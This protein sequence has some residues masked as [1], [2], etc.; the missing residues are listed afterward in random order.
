ML[1][2][3]YIDEFRHAIPTWCHDVWI[4]YKPQD[5]A[6][7]TCVR[8]EYR[9]ANITIEAGWIEQSMRKR[10]RDIL[11]EIV[12]IS[13]DALHNQA[14]DLRNMAVEHAPSAK[15]YLH[16]QLRHALE[17]TTVDLT[18]SIANLLDSHIDA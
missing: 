17:R 6:A 10:R 5:G 8:E 11:H 16:E 2:E 1:V 7:S 14:I 12:H 9:S 18:E 13:L 4:Q 15:D 3:P